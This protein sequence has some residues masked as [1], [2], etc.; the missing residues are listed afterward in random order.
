VEE[1]VEELEEWGRPGVL[2]GVRFA[3][4]F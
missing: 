1:G 3:E 2:F 4:V